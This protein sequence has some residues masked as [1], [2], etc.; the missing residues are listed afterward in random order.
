[1]FPPRNENQQNNIDDPNPADQYPIVE[2]PREEE[3]NQRGI[4]FRRERWIANPREDSNIKLVLTIAA[5]MGWSV[6]TSNVKSEFLQAMPYERKV[7][8][9][10]PKEK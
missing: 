7:F 6:K 1:M 8:V 3:E 9:L 4:V 10:P 2:A 5:I